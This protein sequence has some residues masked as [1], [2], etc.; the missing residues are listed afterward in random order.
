MGTLMT[1]VLGGF[2]EFVKQQKALPGEATL[3]L[4][5]FDNDYEVLHD[6]IDIQNVP[7]LTRDVCFANGST[8]LLD[9]IGVTIN[10]V[11]QKIAAMSE[12]E[13]PSKVLV[14]IYT[15]GQENA[16]HEFTLDKIKEMIKTQRETYSWEFTFTGVGLESFAAEQA[17]DLGID[18]MLVAQMDH[19]HQGTVDAMNLCS[20]GATS[21]RS[22]G[23]HALKSAYKNFK[24]P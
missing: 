3:T 19:N 21:Y 14:S 2:N 10:S 8:A 11:G 5:Q 6:A 12:S 17:R 24:K 15:D 16:S 7:P 4:V 1:D 23:S 13:R 18:P 20:A 22:G 9:A